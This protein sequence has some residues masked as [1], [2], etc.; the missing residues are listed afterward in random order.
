MRDGMEV[1]DGMEM[2]DGGDEGT[3]QRQWPAAHRNHAW[4]YGMPGLPYGMPGLPY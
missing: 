4:P 2:T 1:R 3:G